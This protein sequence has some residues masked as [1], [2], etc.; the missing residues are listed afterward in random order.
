MLPYST[1][2]RPSGRIL[3][4]G[5]RTSVKVSTVAFSAP[6]A[7]RG[8]S[9]S[10]ESSRTI[11]STARNADVALCS[12]SEV[13][14]MPV[15]GMSRARVRSGSATPSNL[16][17]WTPRRSFAGHPPSPYRRICRGCPS[18]RVPWGKTADNHHTSN[19]VVPGMSRRAEPFTSPS[20]V[21]QEGSEPRSGL[22]V[23]TVRRRREAALVRCGAVANTS[24][25]CDTHGRAR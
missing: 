23:A 18:R 14:P 2:I 11:E 21:S 17:V 7:P 10:I 5:S 3:V 15:T 16:V 24:F 6:E 13:E 25:A 19:V 20:R 12:A 4:S 8:A 9:S 1:L 22:G